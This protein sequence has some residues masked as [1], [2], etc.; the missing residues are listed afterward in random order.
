M[1]VVNKL[2]RYALAFLSLAAC[3]AMACDRGSA[4]NDAKAY[5]KNNQPYLA[6]DTLQTYQK[7]CGPDGLVA[8]EI[9]QVYLNL[10]NYKKAVSAW[11]NAIATFDMPE[12]VKLK[13]QL[14]ILSA[15]SKDKPFSFTPFIKAEA[16]YENE[17]D[18]SYQI[19]LASLN[20]AY[21][22]QPVRVQNNSLKSRLQ[23]SL[24][25]R[26][27]SYASFDDES[28]FWIATAGPSFRLGDWLN[29]Y[30]YT[31]LTDGDVDQQS[32]STQLRW[33]PSSWYLQTGLQWLYTDEALRSSVAIGQRAN[34]YSWKLEARS[35]D[36]I[37]ESVEDVTF[38]MTYGRTW[39]L[40]L[41]AK[42]D[43]ENE[44]T[45]EQIGLNYKP[46]KQWTIGSFV[47]FE[48]SSVEDYW[49]T[50]VSLSWLP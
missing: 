17:V 7:D 16:G 45:T 12:A 49:K 15:K 25:T 19:W 8:L 41:R 14:R 20:G 40:K 31:F 38:N 24:T 18:S 42:Q 44:S 22:F 33:K 27:K 9:G 26:Y 3:Q 47:E 39:Q 32:L 10:G 13:V 43:V 23:A 2:T 1:V 21:S 29:T 36:D 48:Q 30:R 5:S 46:R 35:R 50:G 6:L 34:I 11:E 37:D 28:L 4:L